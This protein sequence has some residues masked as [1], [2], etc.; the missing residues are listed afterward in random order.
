MYKN[1][2]KSITDP[3][4]SEQILFNLATGQKKPVELSFSGENIS[5]DG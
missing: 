4:F 3:E 2:K 1:T 5:S